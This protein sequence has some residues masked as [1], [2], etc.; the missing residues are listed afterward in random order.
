VRNSSAYIG[1]YPEGTVEQ[2]NVGNP[3]QMQLQQSIAGIVNPQRMA[4]SG[5]L[6]LVTGASTGGQVYQLNLDEW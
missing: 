1:C 6:L 3:A 5:N 4:F 2:V